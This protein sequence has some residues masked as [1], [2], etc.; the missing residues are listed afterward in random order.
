MNNKRNPSPDEIDMNV[1]EY[2]D[3]KVETY[4]DIVDRNLRDLKLQGGSKRF[5]DINVVTDSINQ[6][7][8]G[9]CA[10]EGIDE[11]EDNVLQSLKQFVEKSKFSKT[12]VQQ[13]Y[14]FNRKRL[15]NKKRRLSNQSK[16]RLIDN[17]V[18]ISS[19]ISL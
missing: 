8:C 2:S 7:V 16:V 15:K 10:R 6:L 9:Q 12:M 1:I 19:D 18:G 11:A 13:I 14:E 17:V 3:D 4:A 5:I